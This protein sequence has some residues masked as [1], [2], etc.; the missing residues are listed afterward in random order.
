MITLSVSMEIFISRSVCSSPDIVRYLNFSM[1]S[2]AFEIYPKTNKTNHF[3][4][5]RKDLHLT[6]SNRF[7]KKIHSIS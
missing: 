5:I 6:K 2:E 1:A 4:T 3:G 7:S